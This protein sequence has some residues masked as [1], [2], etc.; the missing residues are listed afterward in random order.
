MRYANPV[1]KKPD[2]GL[3]PQGPDTSR[4][5][6]DNNNIAPRF[7]FAYKVNQKGTIAVRGGYGIY[8]GR[9]PSIL[10]GTAFT[11][12]GIQ[13][14]TYTLNAATGGIPTYPN[15]LS[16][17]P[18]LNRTPDI[19]VFAK[20][21]VQPLTHQWSVNTEYQLGRNYGLTLGYL[22]VKGEHL[23]R[24]RDINLFPPQPVQGTLN[25]APITFLRYPGTGGPARADTALPRIP[26]FS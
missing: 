25:G 23:T 11:Q 12:N 5:N 20:D 19:Y 15:V 24:T 26:L 2:P 7:G 4:I 21:Y 3:A 17:P 6:Q 8:Y 18:A 1:E 9:T 16:A 14:Q 13:V 22:G 10:T